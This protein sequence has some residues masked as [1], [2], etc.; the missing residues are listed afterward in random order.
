M[1]ESITDGERYWAAQRIT[2]KLWRPGLT[3]FRKS[4]LAFEKTNSG[5]IVYF[6]IIIE[7]IVII[8][9]SVVLRRTV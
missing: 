4:N 1:V 9:V 2:G 6:P 3:G 8:R 5:K 7:L